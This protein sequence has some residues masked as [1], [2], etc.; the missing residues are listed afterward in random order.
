MAR[1]HICF[2]QAQALPWRQRAVG[3][4]TVA[5]KTLSRDDETGA[6][7]EI[8]RLPTNFWHAGPTAFAATFEFYVLQ[9]SFSL[10]DVLYRKDSYAWLPAGQGWSG[11]HSKDGAVVLAMFDGAG[12]EL[13]APREVDGSRA[14]V[15]INAYDIPWTTGAEGSVTGKPLSP[16]IFSKKLRVDPETAEQS[17]LYTALPHHPPPKVMP[18]TFTHPVIEEIFCLSGE[19]VFGD[20][21]KMG[22]G[23]YCWWREGQWHG[24]AGSETGYNLFIRVHGG[25]LTNQFNPE[26][27]P[28]SFTPPH[29]PALPPDMIAYGAPFSFADP[30]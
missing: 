27:A 5:F 23:G 1:P 29:R 19:Y 15:H 9:G 8:L 30:W 16:T 28:F 17:F 2:V 11:W 22:P 7:T 4:Q 20:L 13:V 25:P 26:R 6:T 12:P 3:G 21:G 10:G 18:G 14:I 24:P